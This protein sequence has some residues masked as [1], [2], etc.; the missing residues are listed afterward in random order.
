MPTLISRPEHIYSHP[1]AHMAT[2]RATNRPSQ[3]HTHTDTHSHSLVESQK[4]ARVPPFASA[5]SAVSVAVSPSSMQV[6]QVRMPISSKPLGV[7]QGFLIPRSRSQILAILAS[8]K[9]LVAFI[10]P[11]G[12]S[13]NTL[14]NPLVEVASP[15]TSPSLCSSL[16]PGRANP[17]STKIRGPT[18]QICGAWR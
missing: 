12:R 14:H 4:E 10:K 3:P 9:A 13:T 5:V 7:V 2:H 15:R 11:L 1:E 8:P 18:R 17:S 6:S 16:S